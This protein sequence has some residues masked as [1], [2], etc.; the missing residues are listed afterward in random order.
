[1]VRSTTHLLGSGRKVEGDP[2]PLIGRELERARG[3]ERQ[4]IRARGSTGGAVV[5]RGLLR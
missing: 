5:A 1:M 2:R 3:D 4:G